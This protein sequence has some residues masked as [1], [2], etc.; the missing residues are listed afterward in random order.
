MTVVAGANESGKSSWHAALRLAITGVRRGKGPG[1]AAERQLVE[2]HRPWDQPERWE[3]EARLVLD[4]GRTIDIS[5][6]LGGKV[7]CRAI[8]VELGRDVSDEIMDGTP[9]A[10]RWLGL[11][12]DSFAA[13]VSVN[14]A[15]ILAVAD[16][17]EQL[18]EHMQRAAATR[19][20]DATAAEAIARL[21][22]FRRDA[23]GAD[24]VAAK[25][26]LR[27]A[28]V[29]L[30]AAS[31][32]LAEA[33]R[34][35]ADYLERGVHLDEAERLADDAR[36]RLAG[37]EAASARMIAT[38]ASARA[39]R[40]AELTN[41]HA[42]APVSVAA[43]DELADRVAAA[44]ESWTSRPRVVP[45]TG[46]TSAEIQA[47][48]LALPAV[49][50]GDTRPHPT[51]LEAQRAAAL[52]AD[53]IRQL[54]HRPE[55]A[56][57]VSAGWEPARLRE[58]ARRLRTPQ[59]PQAAVLEAEL[60]RLRGQ[61]A[62]AAPS[63]R[64]TAIPAAAAGIGLLAG[65]TLL[66][67]AAWL[68]GA[69]VLLVAAASGAAALLIALRPGSDRSR[70]RQAEAAL[71]PYRQASAEAAREHARAVKQAADNGL[72]AEAAALDELADRL[73]AAAQQAAGAAE[74][75]VR[76][77]GL[78][79]RE[80]A[81]IGTLLSTL[82][83]RGETV[84]D[85]TGVQAAVDAYLA[86]CEARATQK[87]AAEQGSMLRVELKARLAEEERASAAATRL[88]S[89]AESLRT[90]AAELELRAD[91]D[92]ERLAASLQAWREQRGEAL[93]ANQLALAEWQQLQSL[94]AGGSLSDLQAE[95]GRRRQR[96]NELAAVLPPDSV[97]LPNVDDPEAHVA[98]LRT[99]AQRLR[100][101]YDL[102][103]GN[104]VAR[105]DAL[106]GVAEAEE[107]A[108]IA[109]AELQRV[110]GLA[111]GIDRTLQL[112]R[113][114]EER[115]HRDLAPILS[116]AVARWL[117]IVSRGAYAEISVDPAHLKV[118][119]KEVSSGQWRDA[120]LLSEGTR[121]QIYLLL[122]VAMAQH[123]V[124]T[125]ERAPLLL[126]EVTAQS[127]SDRKRELLDVL[128][129]LSVERQVVL[130]T[131]DDEVVAWAEHSLRQPHDRLVR[132]EPRLVPVPVGE[133]A[134]PPGELAPLAID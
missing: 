51:V 45:L 28:K 107:G 66:A 101:E 50:S 9:D 35:H 53:S 96:A 11:D 18:Q 2:R 67:N 85:G 3:V 78:Q 74:W 34:L 90:I 82:R 81:A 128:H 22:Q 31:A 115:I 97:A 39:T 123:L 86:T 12:R 56:E 6:D 109:R 20:T 83:D 7:A 68:V 54:G 57:T 42:T 8:D 15:Q 13:T 111:I 26:P 69:L 41:R 106:P 98:A 36:L 77:A 4:D 133:P 93:Q 65:A 25:G 55:E 64:A 24:T 120:R 89:I 23:V 104:L 46:R 17:A 47:E 100:G 108:A 105:R 130:F 49:P 1:T 19:G 134:L 103:A 127:D 117:P 44:L 58:L 91:T 121:E 94:L 110:E 71:G 73:V 5:Q 92:P 29:R 16:A 38:E 14:Q 40:A 124:T 112:L 43:R 32:A 119:V 79:S 125:G 10:S 118:S 75:D 88:A 102:A 80:R 76:L 21:E 30:A 99:E 113:A 129:Q 84:A 87:Q 131:H 61:A 62:Q 122:R 126:D 95:A 114:A 37:A 72:P 48:I 63:G 70:I 33:Q 60:A 132:L 116:Q 27:T 52:A 59:L